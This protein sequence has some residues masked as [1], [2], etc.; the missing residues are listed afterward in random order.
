[1][2]DLLTNII[3]KVAELPENQHVFGYDCENSECGASGICTVPL[4]TTINY[5]P[6]CGDTGDES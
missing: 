4:G 3:N 1:M 6:V 2:P 5:C